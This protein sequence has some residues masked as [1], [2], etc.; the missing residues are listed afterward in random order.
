MAMTR[1]EQ[2]IVS[3]LKENPLISQEDI[4]QKLKTSRSSV[5]VHLSNLMKKGIVVGRGYIVKDKPK[6]CVIGGINVDVKGHTLAEPVLYTSNPGQTVTTAGGVARNIA[7][8]LARLQVPTTLLSVVGQ[9]S[10][11][12]RVL[13]ETRDAGV[14]ITQ[15]EKLSGNTGTYT[16]ILNQRGELLVALAAMEIIDLLTPSFLKR[17]EELILS[18]SIIV[19][20]TNLPVDTLRYLIAITND[21]GIPL[22]IEPVSSPKVEKLK[23]IL[24]DKN[25]KVFLAT[26]N[27]AEAEVLAGISIESDADFPVVARQLHSLGIQNILLTLGERGA[28]FSAMK[29]GSELTMQLIPASKVNVKDVTGAG[30]AFVA[31]IIYGLMSSKSIE[32]CCLYG[33]AAASLTLISETTVNS[34]LS[35]SMLEQAVEKL[36]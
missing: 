20:D 11:G 5:A 34:D 24:Q 26:P 16:A 23:N 21:N 2:E 35:S 31:G 17:K 10:L 18:S 4:A 15:V 14:D 36:R 13:A 7:E 25:Q 8:N 9:D 19:C 22:V 30:D 12:E 28:L 29:N 6:V 27:R 33:H 32:D 1:R 3:I